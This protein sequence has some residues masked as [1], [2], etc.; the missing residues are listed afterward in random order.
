[1]KANEIT[2][3]RNYLEEHDPENKEARRTFHENY[4][5]LEGY[6]R[7]SKIKKWI[8]SVLFLVNGFG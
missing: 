1:M 4:E 8:L 5:W 2:L 6:W 3:F 7:N